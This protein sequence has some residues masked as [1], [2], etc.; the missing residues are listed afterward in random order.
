MLQ[1]GSLIDLINRLSP[2]VFMSKW[3]MDLDYNG[4]SMNQDAT[5]W[6]DR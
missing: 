4:G 1:A 3:T 5:C 6:S 2:T